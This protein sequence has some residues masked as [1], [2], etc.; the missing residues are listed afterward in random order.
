MGGEEEKYNSS[1]MFVT[2]NKQSSAIS[3]R[4]NDRWP[5]GWHEWSI[6]L[7]NVSPRSL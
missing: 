1:D 2:Q 6:A 5:M 4:E 3:L 7:G